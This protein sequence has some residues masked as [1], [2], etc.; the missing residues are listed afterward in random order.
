MLHGD[1]DLR[2]TLVTEEM[3]D[4]VP[5]PPRINPSAITSRIVF[6]PAKG[7]A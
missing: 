2:H 5:L 1:A 6:I 4:P 3:L 7:Q